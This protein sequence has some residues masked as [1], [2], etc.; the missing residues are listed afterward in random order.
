MNS[1]YAKW[2]GDHYDTPKLLAPNGEQEISD[3]YIAPDES[4]LIFVNGNDLYISFRQGDDW[5]AGQNLGPQVNNGDGNF[6]PTVS[7]DGKMLYYASARIQ[8]FYKRDQKGHAL[9]Y[10]GL[11]KEM[12]NIF[13]GNSNILMIPIN[14]PAQK[15]GR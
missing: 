14:V 10:D 7:P 1:Y 5:S 2:L 6:D 15:K 13:N 8:G 12:Q 4:Y 11:L 9:D 3:P